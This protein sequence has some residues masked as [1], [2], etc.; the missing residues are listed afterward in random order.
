[1]TDLDNQI[2]Y[3]DTAAT[4]KRFTHPLH[5]PWMDEVDR[6]A[7]ILDYGC[8]YGRTMAHLVRPASRGDRP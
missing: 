5:I 2:A 8:G 6:D 7:A 3:W 4:T 1:M